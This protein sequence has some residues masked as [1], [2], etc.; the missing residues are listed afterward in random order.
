MKNFRIAFAA[1]A[2]TMAAAPLVQAQE[3]TPNPVYLQAV[4]GAD[5]GKVAADA[6]AAVRTTKVHDYYKLV[7][8]AQ[9]DSKLTR[10]EVREETRRAIASG[11]LERLNRESYGPAVDWSA[12]RKPATALRTV[13]A[14]R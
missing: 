3:A 7:T 2:L 4:S 1:A 11:E 6:Y 10:E 13:T 5:A 14:S 12:A 9:N 8:P